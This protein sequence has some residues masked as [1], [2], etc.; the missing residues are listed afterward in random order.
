MLFFGWNSEQPHWHSE[1]SDFQMNLEEG[2]KNLACWP[3]E[4]PDSFIEKYQRHH[5]RSLLQ[6][7]GKEHESIMPRPHV[8]Y[9]ATSPLRHLLTKHC[10]LFIS[11]QQ[12]Y[13][14]SI[15]CNSFATPKQES[16]KQNCILNHI[17][18]HSPVQLMSESRF[19]LRQY[20]SHWNLNELV[21]QSAICHPGRNFWQTD[22]DK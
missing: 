9:W 13:V 19:V 1:E 20:T 6:G 15:C 10:T 7:W 3:Q 2:L 18:V 17:P 21:F 5:E 14:A 12:C 22:C 8:R 4:K 16:K 11:L